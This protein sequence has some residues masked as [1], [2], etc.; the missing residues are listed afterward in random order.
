M[1]LGLSGQS[2]TKLFSLITRGNIPKSHIWPMWMHNVCFFRPF[3][4]RCYQFQKLQNLRTEWTSSIWTIRKCKVVFLFF[5]MILTN[6]LYSIIFDPLKFS[7]LN[8]CKKIHG[9]I[10]P[11]LPFIFYSLCNDKLFYKIPNNGESCARC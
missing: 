9:R 11:N 3:V 4:E 2:K 7:N 6:E 10:T 1:S 8:L 5:T